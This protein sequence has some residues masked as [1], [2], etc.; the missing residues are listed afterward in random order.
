MTTEFGI[1]KPNYN[2]QTTY[3]LKQTIAAPTAN[4]NPTAR[5]TTAAIQPPIPTVCSTSQ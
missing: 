1:P 5:I 2:L 3:L 4:T